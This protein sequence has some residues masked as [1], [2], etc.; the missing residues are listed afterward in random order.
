MWS[1]PVRYEKLRPAQ[2]SGGSSR[3]EGKRTGQCNIAGDS[4]VDL[5]VHV[6]DFTPAGTMT[7]GYLF[8]RSRREA[9][10]LCSN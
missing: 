8:W 5:C 9:T 3:S 7:I 6:L 10:E 4:Y 1:R 2:S